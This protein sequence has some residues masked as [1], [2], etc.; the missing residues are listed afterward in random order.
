VFEYH[1]RIFYENVNLIYENRIKALEEEINE[2]GNKKQL[3]EMA[4]LLLDISKLFHEKLT[5]YE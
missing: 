3:E 5:I 2:L 1:C 4:L